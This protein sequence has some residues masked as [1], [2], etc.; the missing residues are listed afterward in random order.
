LKIHKKKTINKGKRRKRE[1]REEKIYISKFYN[2]KLD[3]KIP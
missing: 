2:K 3:E 1:D